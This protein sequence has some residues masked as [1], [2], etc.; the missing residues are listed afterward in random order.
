MRTFLARLA[1]V[2]SFGAASPSQDVM[3]QAWHWDYP[4]V[5]CNGHVGPSHAA[6][7]AA[8]AFAQ[9]AAGFTRV[10]LPPLSKA[11]FGDCSNGYDPKDLYDIGQVSGRTGVGT[12]AEVAQWIA[13]LSQAGALPVADVVYNH[14]DGGAFEDNPAVRAYVMGYPPPACGGAATPYPVNG[15][16]RYRL[17]LGGSSANGVGDYYFKFSSASGN[18]AFH[19]RAYKLYFRTQNTPHDPNP[20][21]ETPNHGG[22][23]CNQPSD[24]VFLGR[25]VFAL[26]EVGQGCNTDE[27]WLRVQA[28]D[29]VAG[30]DFLEVYVEQVGGGGEG[31]DQRPYGIWS[32]SRGVDVIGELAAQ[33][34]T[35]FSSM[36]SGLGAM[37][38]LDF[39]P[40]GVHAT[41]MTGDLDYPFFFFDVEHAR[42]EVRAVYRD[43]NAWLW[44]TVGIRGFRMD[45]VKHFPASFVG[46]LLDDLH[47][48]GRDPAM[49]VGE[50]FTTHAPTVKGWIDAV[51]GSMSP[52]ARAAI[53]VR[54]FDFEL[55]DAL[56][57]AC[58][59]GL[60]DA[61]QVFQR[62]LV[63][64]AGASGF[65]SV[66]FV[67]NHDFRTPGEHL[68]ARQGLAYA[69]VLTNNRVGLPCVFAPDYYGDDIYGPSS[70]L[71]GLQAEIDRLM[72]VQREFVAGATEAVYLN[73]IGTT[74]ASAWLQCGPQ[75]ALVYQL[76][77]GVAGADVLV[78]INFENQP[79]RVNHAIHVG[80]APLG[81][82]FGLA[83]GSSPRATVTVENSPNGIAGSVYL[84]VPAYS[85]AVYVEGFAPASST[86]FGVGCPPTQPLALAASASRLGTTLVWQTTNEPVAQLGFVAFGFV[87]LAVPLDA[88]G[89]TGCSQYTDIY[90]TLLFGFP[91]GQASVALPLDPAFQGA[92]LHAQS[93]VFAP[94]NPFGLAV[95]NRVTSQL[96]FY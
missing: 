64:G 92:L 72:A 75:D 52:S 41:C 37:S 20:I 49:V 24:R 13:A 91:S 38:R 62:G 10:W 76:R 18:A 19:G 2:A 28:G 27:F 74:Y 33:T 73:R 9:R 85:Y 55:R 15:K 1:F 39:R 63:D 89:L 43:W 88:I 4:K 90:S 30:G 81:T 6:T 54:A 36:P 56:K 16:L 84:E 5:G 22:A 71:P 44:G 25:D 59:N 17:P 60:F 66:T 35:D 45:A 58:D 8:R 95:S 79:M 70:P 34:R 53:D 51:V 65:Q 48:Q 23:D 46:G 3:L 26:Q 86:T 77:G 29:F 94:V 40:N 78:A 42:P 80:A 82:T 93:A 69:Y 14:R 83:A 68:L 50:H 57:Q 12:G 21:Q 67:N 61:R 7:M 31:I 47:A 32:S 96:S 11:S 87:P